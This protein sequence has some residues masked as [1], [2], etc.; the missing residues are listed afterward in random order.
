[1]STEA[2]P[3]RVFLA[4][5]SK[6]LRAVEGHQSDDADFFIGEL[7]AVGQMLA[8]DPEFMRL[9]ANHRQGCGDASA[10]EALRCCHAFLNAVTRAARLGNFRNKRNGGR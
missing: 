9:F 1:M 8:V 2:V 3:I 5:V 7:L 4:L 10:E 6:W